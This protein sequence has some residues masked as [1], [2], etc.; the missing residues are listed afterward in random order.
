M[1]GV[2]GYFFVVNVNH[3]FQQGNFETT[4]VAEWNAAANQNQAEDTVDEVLEYGEQIHNAASMVAAYAA[5]RN[6]ARP[7]VQEEDDKG[8]SCKSALGSEET[9]ATESEQAARAVS[10]SMF[11]RLIDGAQALFKAIFDN[12]NS[13]ISESDVE[14]LS[15][16]LGSGTVSNPDQGNQN[17]ANNGP[18]M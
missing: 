14:S 11:G 7:D 1:L 2:G 4:L 5:S 13:E 10:D 15:N 12:S 8:G 16:R 18:R 3:S 6:S 9:A 17:N